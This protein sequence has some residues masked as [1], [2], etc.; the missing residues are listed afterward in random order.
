MPVTTTYSWNHI[1]DFTTQSGYDVGSAVTSLANGG[2]VALADDGTNI[3]GTI[4][5]GDGN[6]AATW[7]GTAGTNGS[8]AQLSNGNLV[9]A[10]QD[11]DSVIYEIRSGTTGAIVVAPVDVGFSYNGT[12]NPDVTATATGYHIAFQDEYSATDHDVF[13]VTRLND[14]G[15]SLR[16]ALTFTATNEV[17]SSNATLDN[18]NV[19]TTYVVTNQLGTQ[20][21]YFQIHTEAGSIVSPN[22]LV[23]STTVG[24]GNIHASV[25][26]TDT[27]FAIVYTDDGN[28]AQGT[29]MAT[30]DSAGTLI[31]S[32]D[33]SG[34][35]PAAPE[36]NPEVVRLSNGLLAVSTEIVFPQIGGL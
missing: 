35:T 3:A 1:N 30:Y 33:I 31:G 23:D 9:I 2:F 6:I 27:G 7:T 22:I 10:Y 13:H 12:S 20:Q 17:N 15:G 11:A 8:V 32:F 36:T 5:D 16:V 28:P 29:R 19:V 21:V 25:T 26:A 4:F 24:A 14:G 18:G 34:P